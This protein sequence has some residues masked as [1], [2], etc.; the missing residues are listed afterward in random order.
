MHPLLIP[1]LDV[2]VAT[3]S[4]K[5]QKRPLTVHCKTN[6]Q[7]TVPNPTFKIGR[8]KKKTVRGIDYLNSRHK[9]SGFL[10]E[11]DQSNHQSIPPR[12][13]SNRERG[14]VREPYAL[15]FWLDLF[16]RV[17]W[18]G[19]ARFV[20]VVHGVWIQPRCSPTFSSQRLRIEDMLVKQTST[21]S[22]F[23]LGWLRLLSGHVR[24]Y[25][26]EVS[27][28]HVRSCQIGICFR[29]FRMAVQSNPARRSRLR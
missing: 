17:V 24:S 29:P 22:H 9:K 23:Y 4:I 21:A 7:D 26:I 5:S 1:E 6:T 12:I 3:S 10:V 18:E 13:K 2:N 20:P 14:T 27:L 28:G 11:V 16:R 25:Q 19:R 8:W 15:P